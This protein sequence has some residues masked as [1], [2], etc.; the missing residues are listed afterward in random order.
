MLSPAM[1]VS[2]RISDCVTIWLSRSRKINAAPANLALP[3]PRFLPRINYRQVLSA[4]QLLR[5]SANVCG[6]VSKGAVHPC[7]PYRRPARVEALARACLT[8]PLHRRHPR[9]VHTWRGTPPPLAASRSTIRIRT[10]FGWYRQL[11]PCRKTCWLLRRRVGHCIGGAND[12]LGNWASPAGEPS[13]QPWSHAIATWFLRAS[14][15][16]KA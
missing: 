2:P 13:P 11:A 15:S 3:R 16:V 5:W 14:A 6:S 4:K 10:M 1:L 7:A 12:L 8:F 9:N